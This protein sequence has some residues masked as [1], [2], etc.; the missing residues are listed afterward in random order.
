M[1]GNIS[2]L[3][4]VLR[5]GLK[6][7]IQIQ[8]LGP[9]WDHDQKNVSIHVLV[10]QKEDAKISSK[11]IYNHLSSQPI[12]LSSRCNL[13]FLYWVYQAEKKASAHMKYLERLRQKA[14][15]FAV[16]LRA[17]TVWEHMTVVLTCVVQGYP[18]PK[19]RW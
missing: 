13:L 5:P 12:I 1:S 3:G 7:E 16:P 9:A 4:F 10:I 18:P 14:P 19:V 6:I 15:D 17:H 2:G 8:N 11:S